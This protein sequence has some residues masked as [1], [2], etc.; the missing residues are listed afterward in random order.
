MV[1]VDV[2]YGYAQELY[3]WSN[4]VYAWFRMGYMY[5]IASYMHGVNAWVIE[6]Y[7]HYVQGLCAGVVRTD[8]GCSMVWSNWVMMSWRC[9]M[10]GWLSDGGLVKCMEVIR[11]DE[12]GVKK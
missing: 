12:S 11:A 4:G 6:M 9:V 7:I 10:D 2:V 8:Y 1:M 5:Y 3:A